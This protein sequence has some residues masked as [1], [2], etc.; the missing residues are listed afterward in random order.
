MSVFV[1]DVVAPNLVSFS[2]VG[3][4]LWFRSQSLPL[5]ALDSDI[6]RW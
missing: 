2:L 4:D 6:H 1:S 5:T 3:L